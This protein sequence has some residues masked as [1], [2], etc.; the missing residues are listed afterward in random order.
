MCF[1][2]P[3][4]GVEMTRTADLSLCIWLCGVCQRE[5]YPHTNTHTFILRLWLSVYL[6]LF[7]CLHDRFFALFFLFSRL[8]IKTRCVLVLAY[9]FYDC[10]C[11]TEFAKLKIMPRQIAFASC[12]N[13]LQKRRK[14]RKRE[15]KVS[16]GRTLSNRTLFT[17]YPQSISISIS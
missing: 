3:V 6:S 15:T 16:K 4:F 12:I 8:N 11:E 10:A 1:K 7:A 5:N 17:L 14:K 9:G 2:E 13:K